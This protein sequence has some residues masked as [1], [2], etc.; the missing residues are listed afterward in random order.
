MDFKNNIINKK[1][2]FIFF[3]FFIFYSKLWNISLDILKNIFYIIIIIIII[4]YIN[5]EFTIMIKNMI[6][7]LFSNIQTMNTNNNNNNNNNIIKDILS[8]I[9]KIINSFIN[10]LTPNIGSPPSNELTPSSRLFKKVIYNDIEN[11]EFAKPGDSIRNMNNINN[12]INN[13]QL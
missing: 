6:N 9:S 2:L 13:R 12:Y 8:Y 4:N 11:D 7:K 5:P 1:V 3:I 10:I